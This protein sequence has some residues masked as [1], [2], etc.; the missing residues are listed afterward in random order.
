MLFK[1]GMIKITIYTLVDSSFFHFVQIYRCFLL[2][3]SLIC[4]YVVGYK[5]REMF[6]RNSIKI[7]ITFVCHLLIVIFMLEYIRCNKWYKHEGEY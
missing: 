7:F 5:Y 6:M 4:E 3:F 1:F 2:T